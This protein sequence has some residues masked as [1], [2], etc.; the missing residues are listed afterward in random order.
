MTIALVVVVVGL[1]LVVL[2]VTI[3]AVTVAIIGIVATALLRVRHAGSQLQKI[4]V[5]RQKLIQ[6]W[7]AAVDAH[8]KAVTFAV[9]QG[10]DWL[11][12]CVRKC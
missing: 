8:L 6:Q 7:F 1:V 9:K 5:A 12:E 4:T 11:C 3:I 2:V 10:M